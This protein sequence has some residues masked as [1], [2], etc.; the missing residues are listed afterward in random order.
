MTALVLDG[1]RTGLNGYNS[2]EDT[3]D[4]NITEMSIAV[5]K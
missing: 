2:R 5:T 1:L 3:E 4:D